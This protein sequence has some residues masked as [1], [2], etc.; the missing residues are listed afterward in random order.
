[1]IEKLIVILLIIII[2]LHLF[3]IAYFYF[4]PWISYESAFGYDKL[5]HFLG[6]FWIALFF[7]HQIKIKNFLFL[8]A[9]AVTVGVFWEF[10]EFFWDNTFH[11]WIKMPAAQASLADTIWDL[12]WDFVGGLIIS[13]YL[14]KKKP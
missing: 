10:F 9:A 3:G 2:I 14:W 8:I 5:L 6:G 12:F 13:F 7:Y 4:H 11:Y 1:M